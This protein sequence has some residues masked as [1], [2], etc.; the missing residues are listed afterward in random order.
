MR[1]FRGPS[2]WRSTPRKGSVGP[3]PFYS[4]TPWEYTVKSSSWVLCDP[5]EIHV[6]KSIGR[7]RHGQ[8]GHK[9]RLAGTHGGAWKQHKFA[10]HEKARD[11][12]VEHPR[13]LQHGS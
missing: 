8:P 11:H 2:P 9:R 13:I 6:I 4:L 10:Q 7:K 1:V 5:W 12:Q 3:Q